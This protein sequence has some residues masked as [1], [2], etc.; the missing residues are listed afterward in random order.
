MHH[1]I[2][3]TIIKRQINFLGLLEHNNNFNIL[4]HN[5][6]WKDKFRNSKTNKLAAYNAYSKSREKTLAGG[7]G[8][9]MNAEASHK[10]FC[11]GV[12][13]S[14]LGRWVWA[15]TDGTDNNKTCS[16]AGYRPCIDRSNWPN[17]VYT[18]HQVALAK[19]KDF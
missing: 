2:C 16:I 17:T 15:Q 8:C 11:S 5:N 19:K 4:N 1:K 10:I 14:G 9:I 7:T 18:Q 6:Q 3:K 13:S 12:D